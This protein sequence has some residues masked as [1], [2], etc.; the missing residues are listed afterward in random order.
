[1]FFIVQSGGTAAPLRWFWCVLRCYLATSLVRVCSCY[2]ELSRHVVGSGACLPEV[3]A[4]HFAGPAVP[5]LRGALSPLCRFWCVSPRGITSPV[6]RCW[7]AHATRTYLATSSVLVCVCVCLTEVLPRHFAV[8]GVLMLGGP[9]SPLRRL[10]CVCV[11]ACVC[12][13]VYVCVCVCVC[14]S[15]DAISPRPCPLRWAYPNMGAPEV[16]ASA[17]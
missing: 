1:M 9:L 8:S 12:V 4:R 3:L 5:M 17:P 14:V 11:C 16:D 10:W 7:C 15:A 6:R 2:E 13:T